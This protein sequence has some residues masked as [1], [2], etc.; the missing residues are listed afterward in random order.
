M[1]LE[2]A[3]NLLNAVRPNS[4]STSYIEAL[5]V[6]P[7][8][9]DLNV[10]IPC[11][12]VEAYIGKCIESVLS[13]STSYSFKIIA[14]NDGSKDNTLDVLTKYSEN[15]LVSV[16]NQENK[17]IARTRNVGLDNVDSD[18]ILFLDSDD[19]LAPG[20][21]DR[22]MN[23]AKKE[24]ADIVEGSVERVDSD[25][26]DLNTGYYHA[27]TGIVSDINELFG[28]PL[29][30]VFKTELF[31]HVRFPDYEYEDSVNKEIVF[32]L[33]KKLYILEDVVYKYRVNTSSISHTSL[34]TPKCVDSLWINLEL[35]KDRIERFGLSN[36]QDYYEYKISTARLIYLR[37]FK[38]GRDVCK[39]AYTVYSSFISKEFSGYS[40]A[41]RNTKILEW[42]IKKGNFTCFE[43]YMRLKK[44]IKSL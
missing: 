14:V 5:P 36:T 30:K 12:N 8:A 37:T 41:K 43:M 6:K 39:A 31:T 3:Y 17:G 10:V 2:S 18:Y 19:M 34:A 44:I 20:A 9:F 42:I 40:T 16:I 21:I 26:K 13:Q 22:L 32:P 11:Y 27:H 7:K 33:A 25:G 38:Y 28:F 24:N 35:Y 1:N 15:P 23:A 4:E 29:G